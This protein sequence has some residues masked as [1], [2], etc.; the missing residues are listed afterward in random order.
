M[1]KTEPAGVHES[2]A[3]PLAPHSK[4]DHSEGSGIESSS[5]RCE[6]CT[7]FLQSQKGAVADETFQCLAGTSSSTQQ[8]RQP[9]P[10]FPESLG[11][12][13]CAK[14][15]SVQFCPEGLLSVHMLFGLVGSQPER[16][17]RTRLR[18]PVH[19]QQT[20]A[21]AHGRESTVWSI[22]RLHG[23]RWVRNR[24]F[25]HR[26]CGPETATRK[27]PRGALPNMAKWQCALPASVPRAFLQSLIAHV[28]VLL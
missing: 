4:L 26:I 10:H 24:P 7:T 6:M 2:M 23:A 8:C 18:A 22:Y 11:S 25:L 12:L 5:T 21:V 15:V 16:R 14:F 27:S 19:Q 9:F 17:T 1:T 20:P 13:P 28:P 3:I